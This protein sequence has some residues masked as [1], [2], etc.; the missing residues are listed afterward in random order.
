[1]SLQ[2]RFAPNKYKSGISIIEI[3]LVIA[4]VAIIGAATIPL[5]A[6]FLNRNSLKNKTNELVTSLNIAQINAMSGK[7]DSRWGVTVSGNQIVM[8]QGDS[9]STRNSTFDVTYTIPASVSI[10]SFEVVF[11]KVT[12]D[13]D[14]AQNIT[15]SSSQG[16]KQVQVNQLGVVDVI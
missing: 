7:D 13:P 15:V 2:A 4:I 14:S 5:G 6:Q 9:Y 8:F 11:S 16:S 1:M 12:G 10:T 3:I